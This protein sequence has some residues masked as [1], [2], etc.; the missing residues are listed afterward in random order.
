MLWYSVRTLALSS[1]VCALVRT[2]RRG[3]NGADSENSTHSAEM[4]PSNGAGDA[5]P[6]SGDVVQAAQHTEHGDGRDY[7]VVEPDGALIA[8]SH[9]EGK[10]VEVENL[11][12]VE[13]YVSLTE[14]Q[15]CCETRRIRE[16]ND[17]VIH[18]PDPQVTVHRKIV[19]QMVLLTSGS[20]RQHVELLKKCPCETTK[21]RDEKCR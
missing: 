16:Q 14:V 18:I 17:I 20:T 9:V 1:I 13:V 6:L 4:Y 8:F 5:E 19:N 11:N 7:R 12:Q 10:C 3:E 15:G 21:N 2:A